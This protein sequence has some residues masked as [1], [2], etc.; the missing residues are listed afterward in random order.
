MK[1][2]GDVRREAAFFPEHVRCG[3]CGMAAKGNFDGGREPAQMERAGVGRV[4][5]QERGF[6]QIHF[7]RDISHPGF[8]GRGLENAHG[9]WIPRERRGGEGV[10]LDDGDFVALLEE[11]P[12]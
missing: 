1:A 10:D 4:G 8:V 11:S 7:A 2:C 5:S 9:G 3:E 6:R 12:S